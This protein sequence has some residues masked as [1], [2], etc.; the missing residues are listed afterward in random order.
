MTRDANPI[1]RLAPPSWALAGSGRRLPEETLLLIRTS[2]TASLRGTVMSMDAISGTA[3][4]D[5]RTAARIRLRWVPRLGK[6][7]YRVLV[8][9]AWQVPGARPVRLV[10]E[11]QGW[12]L[13]TPDEMEVLARMII[14]REGR[15]GGPDRDAGKIAGR[16]MW[17]ADGFRSSYQPGDHGEPDPC[18]D[19]PLDK[20]PDVRPFTD[21]L[22]V[23]V[24][25]D[26]D[27]LARVDAILLPRA[28]QVR[29]LWLFFVRGD[30]IQESLLRQYPDLPAHPWSWGEGALLE[31]FG[32]RFDSPTG[33]VAVLTRPGS[34]DISVADRRWARALQPGRNLE[35]AHIR[36]ICL[37]TPDGVRK[38]RPL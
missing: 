29:S 7:Y 5:L 11:G 35:P 22:P 6:P 9:E 36:M 15:S 1:A 17:R 37:A 13:L 30:G 31:G 38:L 21:L 20:D 32:D 12:S 14:S 4:C 18:D 26:A 3:Q 27:V 16:L 28:R 33:I 10:V 24:R 19:E 23:P 8:L 2:G 34:A 25:T